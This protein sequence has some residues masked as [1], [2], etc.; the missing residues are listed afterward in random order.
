M[1]R[2]EPALIDST[3]PRLGE[4][5]TFYSAAC[6]ETGEVEHM[7]VMETCTAE[8]STAFIQ[9]LR[10]QYPN[11]HLIVIWDWVREEVT[12]NPC[13]GT[14]AKVRQKVGAF[15]QRLSARTDEAKTRL[16]IAYSVR[17]ASN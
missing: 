16:S 4:K 8:T 10:A 6:L 14:K 12:A 17:S 2:G 15:S 5:V 13:L 1:L 11:N 3:S 7:E 9:Q